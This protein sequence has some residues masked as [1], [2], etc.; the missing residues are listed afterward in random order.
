MTHAG[1]V[2]R[3]LLGGLQMSIQDNVEQTTHAEFRVDDQWRRYIADCAEQYSVNYDERQDLI[4]DAVRALLEYGK[5]IEHPKSFIWTT[6][7]RLAINRGCVGANARE[8]SNADVLFEEDIA[9]A[10]SGLS[11]TIILRDTL[12]RLLRR[13]TPGE[14]KCYELLKEGHEQRDLPGIMG[15]SR[16]AVSKILT[17]M[18]RKYEELESEDLL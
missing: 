3:V 16:Q 5:P 6:V 15:V 17:S 4:S 10:R 12:D 9:E 2:V 11:E 13:L 8:F 14:L 1:Y 7:R 18:R